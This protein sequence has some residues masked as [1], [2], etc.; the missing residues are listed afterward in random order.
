MAK[1]KYRRKRTFSEKALMVLG[2]LIVISMILATV[3]SVISPG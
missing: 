2:I 3:A 1:K